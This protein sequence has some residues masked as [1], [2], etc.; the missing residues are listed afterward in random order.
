MQVWELDGESRMLH[1]WPHPQHVHSLVFNGLGD[2]L[3]SGCRDHM[4]RVFVV[5]SDGDDDGENE[6]EIVEAFP[7]KP[8]RACAP[9]FVD[10]KRIIATVQDT[11]TMRWLDTESEDETVR[12][13]SPGLHYRIV[14]PPCFRAWIAGRH[15]QQ[16]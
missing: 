13:F 11:N 8:Y 4:A 15:C 2:R 9:V 10:G 1:N 14:E 7:H 6:N 16:A 12:S 5:A 3:A